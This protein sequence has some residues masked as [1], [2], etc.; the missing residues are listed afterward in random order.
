M[1]GT[2][3]KEDSFKRQW[4]QKYPW[5]HQDVTLDKAFSHSCIKAKKIGRISA[6]KSIEK[7]A[8]KTR[9][10]KQEESATKKFWIS[11]T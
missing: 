8:T 11:K 7:T 9:F 6:T 10:K 3:L 4:Y 1:F 2:D 5:L